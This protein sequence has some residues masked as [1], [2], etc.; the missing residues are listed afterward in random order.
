MIESSLI[1]SDEGILDAMLLLAR[2]AKSHR[3][4]IAGPSAFD[5]YL[6]LLQRGFSR[7]A[8]PVTCRIPC[9]QHDVAL[10]AGHQSIQALETLMDRIIPFLNKRAALAIWL[11]P[12][13]ADR[14]RRFQAELE[15]LGF[16]IEARAQCETGFILSA[17]RQQ[18]DHLANAA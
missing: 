16:R 5:A 10:I 18:L 9:G 14:G 13:E 11:G 15:R 1:V 3:I 2:A 17:R 7:A 8:T 6:G 12:H 4:M